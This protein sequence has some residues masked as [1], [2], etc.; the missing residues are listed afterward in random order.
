[1]LMIPGLDAST[2]DFLLPFALMLAI[3]YGA[4]QMGSPIKNKGVNFI[5]ALVL[6][7]FAAT[8]GPATEM[9]NQMLPYAAGLFVAVFLLGF[10][11]S[12]FRQKQGE[13]TD[14]TLLAIIAALA[15]I[16]LA[17]PVGSDVFGSFQTSGP[18]SSENLAAAAGLVFVL[19]MLVAAYK[20]WSSR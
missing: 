6:A 12:A 18:L 2:L 14:F 10:I 16:F 3:A 13:K 20:R 8:Y 15:A 5:V 1:M 4:L 7:L 11:K 9:I 17:S 19:V